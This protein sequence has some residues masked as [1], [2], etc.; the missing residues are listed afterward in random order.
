MMRKLLVITALIGFYGS[1]VSISSGFTVSCDGSRCTSLDPMQPIFMLNAT[2]DLVATKADPKTVIRPFG[3]V[4]LGR[5]FS[6]QEESSSGTKGAWPKVTSLYAPVDYGVLGSS[7]NRLRSDYVRRN[8]T[9]S[10]GGYNN[11]NDSVGHN[12]RNVSLVSVAVMNVNAAESKNATKI[13]VVTSREG[14]NARP[15]DGTCTA[16]CSTEKVARP[17]SFIL[18]GLALFIAGGLGRR[19]KFVAGL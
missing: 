19:T 11:A 5:G 16:E 9:S 8:G 6:V 14:A 17:A 1:A 2:G 15:G 7:T 10:A 4:R 18:F 3:I 12:D 13:S